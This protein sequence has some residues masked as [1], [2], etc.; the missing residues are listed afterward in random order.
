MLQIFFTGLRLQPAPG[1]EGEA[2]KKWVDIM[3]P[4][5]EGMVRLRVR[6]PCPASCMC[7]TQ[8]GVRP[9]CPLPAHMLVRVQGRLPCVLCLH[10]VTSQQHMN[11]RS[12]NAEDN[13]P[14]ALPRGKEVYKDVERPCWNVVSLHA[15]LAAVTWHMHTHHQSNSLLCR[16]TRA[17]RKSPSLSLPRGSE[18]FCFMTEA[19]KCLSATEGL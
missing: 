10:G 18:I 17:S 13:W 8:D 6:P 5:N 19:S 15:A 4:E 7:H 11:S 2:L 12:F 1:T 14:C 3:Q 16:T 9:A